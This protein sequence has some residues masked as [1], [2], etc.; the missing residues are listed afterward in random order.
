MCRFCLLVNIIV[1]EEHLDVHR[2]RSTFREV[3]E[4]RLDAHISFGILYQRIIHVHMTFEI[5]QQF[6]QCTTDYVWSRLLL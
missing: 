5:V 3:I 1:S 2:E 6:F 4:D